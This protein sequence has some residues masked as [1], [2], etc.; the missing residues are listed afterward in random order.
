MAASPQPEEVPVSLPSEPGRDDYGLPP[1]NVVVPDDAR[2]LDRDLLAYRRERKAERRRQRLTRFL[3]PFRSPEF[4]GRAAII[5]LIAVCLAVSLIG[6]A[7]L[8]VATMGPAAAPTLNQPQTAPPAVL[9]PLPDGTVKV[10]GAEKRVRSLV[11]SVMALVPVGCACD[12]ALRRL[13]AQAAA[14][15]VT[16]YFV[17]ALEEAPQLGGLVDQD[18]GGAAVPVTDD[19]NVLSDTFRP[20]SLTVLLVYQDA[21]AELHRALPADFQLTAT[22]GKLGQAAP[23]SGSTLSLGPSR[24]SSLNSKLASSRSAGWRVGEIADPAQ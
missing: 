22:M 24:T 14:A 10:D 1:V 5:P 11:S 13:S 4:G 21:T 15:K 2:E 9:T 12:P 16:L 8:S 18:S 20:A 7:L 3:R 6:G 23:S 19:Q 17:A